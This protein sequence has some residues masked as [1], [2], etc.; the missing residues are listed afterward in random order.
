MAGARVGRGG[1]RGMWGD[2]EGVRYGLEDVTV[3]SVLSGLDGLLFCG[4][5]RLIPRSNGG[6]WRL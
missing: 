5:V 3:P 1:D 4:V 2:V 6:T